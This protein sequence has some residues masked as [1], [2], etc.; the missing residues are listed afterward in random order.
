[1]VVLRR[2]L[3]NRSLRTFDADGRVMVFSY[4]VGATTYRAISVYALAGA[5]FSIT[6]FQFM[7]TLFVNTGPFI[8][9]GDFNSF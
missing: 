7:G 5:P 8:V 2:T 1:M 6:F 9:Y 4:F 3:L